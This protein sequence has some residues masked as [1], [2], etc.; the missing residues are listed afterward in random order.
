M[1]SN[2]NSLKLRTLDSP[3]L[4]TY[5]Q[6]KLLTHVRFFS[7]TRPDTF[8]SVLIYE[9]GQE[10]PKKVFYNHAKKFIFLRRFGRRNTFFIYREI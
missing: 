10:P 5:I 4:W 7:K 1:Q 6:L 2:F 8:R 9:K 3:F